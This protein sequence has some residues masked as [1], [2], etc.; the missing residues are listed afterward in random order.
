MTASTAPTAPAFARMSALPALRDDLHLHEAS[1]NADG[2]P[3]W[4]I[5]DP[6]GNVFYRIGWLEFELLARWHL[7]TVEAVLDATSAGTLLQPT[8]DELQALVQ[9][10][11]HNHLLAI[12]GPGL[13]D[14]LVDGYRRSRLSHLQRLLHHYLF[15]RVPLWRPG[16]WLDRML[17]WVAWL[18]RP[19]AAYALLALGALGLVLM[20]RQMDV[21]FASLVDT[22]SPGG[23]AAYAVALTVTKSLHEL[24]HAFTATRYRVR[25][26][27]MGV[28]FLVLWPVLYTDTGESWKLKDRKQ[29]LAIAS[30][31]I[32]TELA[33]AGL[34]LLGWALTAPGDLRQALF[35]LATTSLLVSLALNASPFMR[36]DGYFILSDVLGFENLHERSSAL[37]RTWLRRHLLGWQD[38]YPEH[39]SDARRRWLIAFAIVTWVYRLS[40]FLAIAA[41]VYFMFFKLL[42]ILLFVV[43]IAWF[44]VRPF[45]TEFKVWRSRSQDIVPHRKRLAW[46]AGAAIA[47]VAL[48]P[49]DASVQAHGMARSE[50]AH[51]LFSPG[52]AQVVRMGAQPG[53]VEKDA[54]LIELV[55]PEGT[56]RATVAQVGV[57]ALESQLAGLA[58]VPQGEEK[59]AGLE[60]QQAFKNLQRGAEEDEAL[61]LQLRAPI[62]GVL[63]D[64]DPELAPGVWVSTRQPLGVVLDPAHWTLDALVGQN[65]LQRIRVGSP[66]QFY[67]Q[68]SAWSPWPGRVV[69]VGA[70]QLASLPHPML[71][72]RFG[73]DVAVL[74]DAGGLTPRDALYRVRIQLDAAP[75]NTAM[76]RGTVHLD[77]TPQS[78]FFEGLRAALAVLVREASF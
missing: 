32:V 3:A 19:A 73:G 23:F 60:Q 48:V 63:A 53:A 50:V 59:R 7:G 24:G 57:S 31:G 17:P 62:R 15:F 34:A 65:D 6:V 13:T 36:F 18:Y 44:V 45:A 47:V 43:E 75:K 28:A 39:F 54:L 71:S 26:A 52:P 20:A 21:F 41:A 9:F 61:R 35:F 2:S 72:A 10:L 27:H 68:G 67:P 8:Q 69:D 78:W 51:V 74:D 42:G 64:L 49:W 38:P 12:R 25:V 40:V 29:R 14:S 22:F 55:Q 66:V 33:V 16:T 70:S 58:S 56:L 4:T 11:Q 46:L 77:A 5:Q 1:P 30:A 76:R 37:A